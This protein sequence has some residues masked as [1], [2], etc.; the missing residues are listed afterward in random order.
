MEDS[1]VDNVENS[2]AVIGLSGRFPGA[3]SVGQFWQNIRDGVESISFF[4][5]EELLKAGVEQADLVDSQYIKAKGILDN[6]DMFDAEFF[7]YSPAEAEFMDPQQ[8][9][10]LE[11][12]WSALENAGYDADTYDGLIG[13]YAG[14]SMNSYFLNNLYP[15]RGSGKLFAYDKDF[16]ATRLSYKMNLK[17]PSIDIQTACS[18]SLVAICEACQSLLDY[19][20]DIAL[21]GGVSIS[22]PHKSGYMHREGSIASSDGHCRAFDADASGTVSGAGVGVV[23]LKRLEDALADGDDINAVIKGFSVNNDGSN[24]VGYSAPSVSGQAEVIAMALA[25]ADVEA[26]SIS[27][28]ECHGTGTTLG[29]P[30]EIAALTRAFQEST[31][32][33]GYCAIG[34]VKTNIGHLDAA[35]GVTGLIKTVLSLQHTQ[36]PPSLNYNKPNPKI[37]F[38]NSPFYV[39]TDLC[40]WQ[41]TDNAPRRAG[42][43]SFGIGGTNAH[44]VIEEAPV[45]DEPEEKDE[46]QL[47]LISARTEAALDTATANLA[48]HLREHPKQR[49]SDVAYTLQV[50]RRMFDHRRMLVCHD[51][52]DAISVFEQRNTQRLQ[53]GVGEARERQCVFMFS[54]QGSQY[55]NMMRDLY[56]QYPVFQETVLDCCRLLQ[57]HLGLNLLELLYPQQVDEEAAAERLTETRYTQPALF[58]VEYALA[59]LW[60]SW[61]L[62]PSAMIGHSIGEYVAACLAGVFTLEDALKLVADRGRLMQ[63]QPG[64]A[65]LSVT[66]AAE[67]IEPLLSEELSVAVVNAPSICVVSGPESQVESFAQRMT[68]NGHTVSRLHTSHAFHSAMMQPAADELEK[69]VGQVPMS[70]P[71]IPLISNVSGD[72]I[73]EKQ[74]TDPAYWASHLRSTVQFSAGIE[75]LLQEQ[76]RWYLEAGPG[77][78]LVNLVRQNPACGSDTVVLPSVRHPRQQQDD[79]AFILGTL[80][81]SWLAGIRPD[82]AGF[83]AGK[84]RHRIPLSSYPFERKKYWVERG[85]QHSTGQVTEASGKNPDIQQ[86][87]YA[88]A[89]RSSLPA[90]ADSND[91]KNT[92]DARWLVFM[93]PGGISEQLATLIGQ[94]GEA[95][96]KVREGTGF[97]N[98][99]NH[100]YT[101]DPANA[102]DYRL[103]L[104]SIAAEQTQLTRIVHLWG[105]GDEVTLQQ[106]LQR[107]YYSLLYLAQ[108]LAS[109]APSKQTAIYMVHNGV[110]SVIGDEHLCSAKAPVL[111]LCKVIP[112]ELQGVSCC[113]IDIETAAERQQQTLERIVQECLAG[114]Q[115]TVVAYRRGKRWLQDYRPFECGSEQSI[116][117]RLREQGVYL[118]TGG[119]GGLGLVL[120]EYLAKTLSARLVLTVRS[121]IPERER[122]DQWLAEHQE[123]D[124]TCVTINRL[125]KLEGAGAEVM[126]AAADAADSDRMQVVLEQ[127][128]Q[129]F[130]KIHGVIHAAG[131]VRGSSFAPLTRLQQQDCE[132]QF[133]AKING[134]LVLDELFASRQPDFIIAMSSLAALLGGLGMACYAAANQFMDSFVQQQHQQGHDYWLSMNWDAWRLQETGS[135]D[136]LTGLAALAMN[137][138]EGAAVFDRVLR[139]GVMPQVVISTG[140]LESRIQQWINPQALPE[141]SEVKS[142]DS[143]GHARPTL[144]V[145]FTEARTETEKNIV[146]IWQEIFKISELGIHD[147]FFELGGHSLM[148][149]QVVSLLRERLNVEIS[150]DKFLELGSVESLATYVDALNSVTGHAAESSATGSTVERDEFDL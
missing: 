48:A 16:I 12:S 110:H 36:I 80:G 59:K 131:I 95:V 7:G 108:A 102:D 105:I 116:P 138:E 113:C 9:I 86:W 67:E 17:G 28:V 45:L 13:V 14:T 19:R 106:N 150:I 118:I 18:T 101:I 139:M 51:R 62:Q 11:S 65:M 3:D 1:R 82:W 92:A 149:I 124:K 15:Y 76:G 142:A 27:Y 122:W 114:D 81:Q 128:E 107:G 78:T 100:E 119:L 2:I 58:V 54:G 46:Y 53:S 66:L 6:P 129:R 71:T 20:C 148:A 94:N 37:D 93:E 35:A 117:A 99:G 147:N 56:Q 136:V 123:T 133:H 75:R 43:S 25:L 22:T 31:N 5:D 41:T 140:N 52:N 10:F 146:S 125:L 112:Q 143:S 141:K 69:L 42:V 34:S 79:C 130:G 72:W 44:V 50:G 26:D 68:E 135:T 87:C 30:I 121:E 98:D 8:R 120:A 144:R 137:A 60:M 47:L 84:R 97:I 91:Q 85:Q 96:V 49:L 77:N 73:N 57:P 132:Q 4:T 70:P 64:G 55:P 88:P 83:H 61:G 29:D 24:K 23:V 126:V 109:R 115:Q 63:A 103:L 104:E 21:S 32:R 111:A 90:R 33:V 134:T 38:D 40:D 74:A 89:W 145:P 127:A 39:N